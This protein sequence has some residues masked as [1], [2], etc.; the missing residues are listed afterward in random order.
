MRH[1]C[2]LITI[3]C[4]YTISQLAP[5]GMFDGTSDLCEGC[6]VFCCGLEEG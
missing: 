5:T 4:R 1:V 2:Y 3:D 6:A